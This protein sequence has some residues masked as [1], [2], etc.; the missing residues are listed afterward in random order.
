MSLLNIIDAVISTDQAIL[1][2]SVFIFFV[3]IT[4]TTASYELL[5]LDG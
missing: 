1:S 3:I 5:D 2:S 4:A